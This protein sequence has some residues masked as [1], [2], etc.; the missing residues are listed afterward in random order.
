MADEIR[1]EAFMNADFLPAHDRTSMPAADERIATAVEY[2]AY[3]MGQINRKLDSL[4][5]SLA[6]TAQRT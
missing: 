3:Q 4:S 6:R 1:M 5:M 2:M